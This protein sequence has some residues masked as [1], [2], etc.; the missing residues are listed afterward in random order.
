MYILQGQKN[1]LQKLKQITRIK[2]IFVLERIHLTVL[3]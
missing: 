2:N 3:K 1:I